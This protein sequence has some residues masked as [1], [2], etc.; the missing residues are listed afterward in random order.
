MMN[1]KQRNRYLGLFTIFLGMAVEVG[2][3]FLLG[4]LGGFAALG[5]SA[6]VF[7]VV[8]GILVSSLGIY[9]YL[10]NLP[11]TQARIHFG[12]PLFFGSNPTQNQLLTQLKTM[13]ASFEGDDDLASIRKEIAYLLVLDLKDRKDADHLNYNDGTLL[14]ILRL[15]KPIKCAEVNNT[16]IDLAFHE[17]FV[18]A[19][20]MKCVIAQQRLGITNPAGGATPELVDG[21]MVYVLANPAV[22]APVPP[23]GSPGVRM[24]RG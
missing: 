1:Y 14:K 2:V 7:A 4:F 20:R 5:Y 21:R 11:S 23:A 24:E 9:F 10:R 17:I 15:L 18:E 19:L 22:P 8:A 16:E 6:V 12:Y 3:L 13:N